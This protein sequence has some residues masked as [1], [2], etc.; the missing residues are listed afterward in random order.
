MLQS[1]YMNVKSID[2]TLRWKC[3]ETSVST[4]PKK[5]HQPVKVER[6]G[7]AQFFWQWSKFV[8]RATSVNSKTSRAYCNVC[9]T[10]YGE[11]DH[12]NEPLASFFITTSPVPYLASDPP[13]FGRKEDSTLSTSTLLSWFSTKP[14]LGFSTNQFRIRRKTFWHYS[15]HWEDH[16]RATESPSGGSLPEIENLTTLE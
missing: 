13:V 10:M 6:G 3:F 5:I 15:R 1:V 7:H 14:L 16:D 11:R 9:E 12:K 8:P 4:S 2:M